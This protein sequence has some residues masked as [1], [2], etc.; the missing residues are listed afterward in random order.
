MERSRR[1]VNP[2]EMLV[3]QSLK[4]VDRYGKREKH[5]LPA[6]WQQGLRINQWWE[7]HR[8]WGH[9]CVWEWL[10][11]QVQHGHR[12]HHLP[13]SSAG[14]RHP[15]RADLETKPE[16]QWQGVVHAGESH[17]K[18]GVKPRWFSF[19]H[20]RHRVR[21]ETQVI[22]RP[23]TKCSLLTIKILTLRI[24]F[25]IDPWHE[26]YT[27]KSSDNFMFLVSVVFHKI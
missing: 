6:P 21:Q 20:V 5:Q 2:D 24:S 19:L 18:C 27:M 3:V 10:S 4:I 8:R 25:I 14:H 16:E 9:P 26:L 1:A 22:I 23:C 11:G 17:R 13:L 12:R 15:L 7:H